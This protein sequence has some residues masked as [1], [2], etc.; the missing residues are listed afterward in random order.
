VKI[1]QNTLALLARDGDWEAQR[2]LSAMQLHP[3][4][5]A[6]E[7]FYQS[8][9]YLLYAPVRNLTPCMGMLAAPK[10]LPVGGQK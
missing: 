1:S 9:L 4:T 3:I 7:V 8:E 10:P 2:A 5:S 6:V